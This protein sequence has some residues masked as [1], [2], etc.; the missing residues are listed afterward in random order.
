MVTFL[1]RDISHSLEMSAL[2]NVFRGSRIFID[3]SFVDYL[4][5][6]WI[7]DVVLT[8]WNAL[9]PQPNY[10]WML[11]VFKCWPIL[12]FV[13][14]TILI[15]C[16]TC[17]KFRIH[18]RYKNFKQCVFSLTYFDVQY[19]MERLK[20]DVMEVQVAQINYFLPENNDFFL[21][22]ALAQFQI[23]SSV[24]CLVFSTWQY[25]LY[26]TFSHVNGM[27]RWAI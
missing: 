20:F 14:H 6:L 25:A 3:S 19:T 1:Q 24:S 8:T 23:K 15:I 27:C 18:V 10:I 9:K 2:V 21:L 11:S 4:F 17:R 12:V 22:L 16:I 13:H 5:S 7:N 26:V